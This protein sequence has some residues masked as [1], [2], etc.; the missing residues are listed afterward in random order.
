MAEGER[1]RHAGPCYR[2]IVIGP[3]GDPVS[4]EP[5]AA[6]GDDEAIGLALSRLAEHAAELWDG[7]RL[8]CRL[9]PSLFP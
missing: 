8:V 3:D 4:S 9:A 7:T 5:L 1:R 2:L 6:G